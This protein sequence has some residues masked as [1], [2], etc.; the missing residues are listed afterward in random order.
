M[1]RER[2]TRSGKRVRGK[3]VLPAALKNAIKRKAGQE[4]KSVS[5]VVQHALHKELGLAEPQDKGA[6]RPPRARRARN[7]KPDNRKPK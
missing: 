1:K 5:Q 7:P 6:P 3:V 2:D 4:K